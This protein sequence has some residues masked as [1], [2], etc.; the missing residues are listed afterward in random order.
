[1]RSPGKPTHWRK[2]AASVGTEPASTVPV[3]CAMPDRPLPRTHR[4]WLLAALAYFLVTSLSHLEVSLWLVKQRT[5]SQGSFAFK[6]FAPDA[7]VAAG[8]VLAA[9]LAYQA[10]KAVRPW[11]VLALWALLAVCVGLV[12]RFLTFSAAEYAHY[13]QYALL[14]WLLARA[15]DPE[16]RRHIPGRI[17][18]WTTLLGAVDEIVQYLWITT[19]YSEYLDFNDILVNMI[20][21]MA[22][23]LLYYGFARRT[24]PRAPDALDLPRVEII[25]ALVLALAIG[26]ALQQ[27]CIMPHTSVKLAHSA[28]MRD[29]GDQARLRL[30]LQRTV[31]GRHG[32][33]NQ[34]PYRGKHWIL[35]PASAAALTLIGGGLFGLLATGAYGA[36]PARTARTALPSTLKA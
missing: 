30:Y 6:D 20:G 1:M 32:S 5:G 26:V 15:L 29:A 2:R 23:I 12:D 28:W 25:T 7:A 9:W 24:A 3:H 17:L 31:P 33:Y 14:T 22:G 19:S 13:P 21:G 27:Q 10:W 35:D 4:G 36:A 11:P 18:L 16:R 34:G 8:A